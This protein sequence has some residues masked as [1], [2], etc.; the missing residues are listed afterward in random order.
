MIQ[1]EVVDV[2]Y[3]W[4]GQYE[5][6]AFCMYAD[7]LG[8]ATTGVGNLIP[9]AVALVLPWKH[10]DGSPASEAEIEDA[11]SQIQGNME[12]AK[13][14]ADY[15]CTLTDLRLSREG[16]E[17]LVQ[18]RLEQNAVILAGRFPQFPD[19]PAD[20]QLAVLSM[21]WAMGAGFKFPKFEASIKAGDFRAAAEESA[22]NATGNPGVIPRN[23]ENKKLL[24]AA[25][26]LWENGGDFSRLSFDYSGLPEPRTFGEPAP[27]GEGGSDARIPWTEIAIGAALGAA[28][29]AL[30]APGVLTQI[31]APVVTGVD[32]VREAVKNLIT[33]GRRGRLQPGKR[34][35]FRAQVKE[36]RGAA[37]AVLDL[38]RQGRRA[39]AALRRD[40]PRCG[41]HARRPAAVRG[42]P[43]GEGPRSVLAAASG[44]LDSRGERAPGALHAP[45]SGRQIPPV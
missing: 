29:L 19:W 42:A 8:L 9:L 12:A 39:L 21:A 22:I 37:P 45:R 17:A 4:N 14:G 24:L 3:R 26:D 2:F 16:V 1:A 44:G 31:V 40:D 34:G 6:V 27:G 41:P 36:P 11:W 28:A 10:P 38:G 7:I 30:V 18:D 20:A 25:A 32:A 13:R 43:R 5:G 23:K 35:E 33:G 15:A